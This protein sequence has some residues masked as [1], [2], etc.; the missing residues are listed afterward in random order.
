MRI[1]ATCLLLLASPALAEPVAGIAVTR[2]GKALVVANRDK[3]IRVLALPGGKE[4]RRVAFPEVPGSVAVSPDGKLLAVGGFARLQLFDLATGKL[5]GDARDPVGH[6]GTNSLAFSPDG[7][8]LAVAGD[9]GR[10]ALF[11][12]VTAK[13]RLALPPRKA[14]VNAVA[15]SPDGKTLASAGVDN[16][17]TL[18]SPDGKPGLELRGHQ[19]WIA[20]CIF[21]PDGKQIVSVDQNAHVIVWARVSG[22]QLERMRG[23]NGYT[24]AIAASP[25]GKTLAW[26]AEAGVQL[27]SVPEKKAITKLPTTAGAVITAIGYTPD[28]KSLIV[29]DYKGTVH[30][31]DVAKKTRG[32]LPR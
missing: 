18:W 23:D 1:L 5:L 11:D 16:V 22:N 24:Y 10:L 9:F 21:S 15:W 29:G 25:D 2:D 4:L 8:T 13:E 14:I 3:T 20:S 30:V 32:E 31:F 17:V 6:G 26:G 19:T 27:W 28:G 7:K 12:P